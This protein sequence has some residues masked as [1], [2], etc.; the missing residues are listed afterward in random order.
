MD[1]LIFQS[2][3]CSIDFQTK[4]S[5]LY[6]ADWSIEVERIYAKFFNQTKI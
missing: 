3:F 4:K 1:S 2:Q 6:V 5:L